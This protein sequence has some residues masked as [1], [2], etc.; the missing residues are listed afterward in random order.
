M[1][2]RCGVRRAECGALLFVSFVTFMVHIPHAEAQAPRDTIAE[3]RV[4]GNHTTP[5]ADVLALAG[6]T[7]G[8]EASA[9]RLD[10]AQARLRATDRFEDVQVLRRYRSIANPSEILV[11]VVIDEHPA[12]DDLDLTPGPLRKLRAAGMWMP[13]IS[14]ADGYGFTYGARLTVLEPLGPKTR[15]SVPLT[16]GGE[17]R[18]AGELERTFDRGP[19]HRVP[20][21]SVRGGLSLSRRVNPHF[22]EPDRR[23]EAKVRA[24]RSITGWLRA[25]AGA[26]IADVQFGASTPLGTRLLDD[27]IQ[28]AGADITVDT[29]IDP[30]FPRNAVHLT[31]G[32]EQMAFSSFKPAASSALSEHSESKGAGRWTTDLRG[33]VGVWRSTVVAVR[34]NVV[35][36]DAPLP[37]YEQPL[38]G[39]SGSVRGYRTG[40]RAGDSVATF[41]AEL[42]IPLS[43]PLTAGRFGAKT[44]VDWGTTWADGERM[45]DQRFDRGIGG[46]VY[47]GAGP[48]I[49][50]LD[51]AW[52]RDGRARAHFGLGVSF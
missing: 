48:V 42:R 44:F 15:F 38:L 2:A 30:S 1:S 45:R 47:L 29:R 51:V 13:I 8:E 43:S 28:A 7:L 18:V 50:D 49:A 12:V 11:V 32:W 23:L 35:R 40:H 41:S 4:H 52:P 46:G 6:L 24:D 14:H 33:Y 22:A 10:A 20:F 27:R 25:S 5:D 19:F 17:R 21:D 39:G 31:T 16:W 36:S 9:E 37:P 3:I 26:R 34:A